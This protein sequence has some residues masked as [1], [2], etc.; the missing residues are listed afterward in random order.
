MKE[1]DGKCLMLSG[2]IETKIH[3]PWCKDNV[4]QENR[5]EK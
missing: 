3:Y 4:F 1:P 2:Q 5:R